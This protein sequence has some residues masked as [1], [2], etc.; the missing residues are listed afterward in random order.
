MKNCPDCKRLEDLLEMAQV[1]LSELVPDRSTVYMD[2]SQP[3][4]LDKFVYKGK[5]MGSVRPHWWWK[6]L[7]E[8]MTAL[9]NKKEV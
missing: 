2:S 5:H 7:N 1:Y 8:I 3:V 9:E 4:R 6:G